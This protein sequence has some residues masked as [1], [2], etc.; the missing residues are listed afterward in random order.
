MI[1]A[2][3]FFTGMCLTAVFGLIVPSSV[4]AQVTTDVPGIVTEV[5]N[6]YVGKS[7]PEA[8]GQQTWQ[9]VMN[10]ADSGDDEAGDM[11]LDDDIV[12]LTDSLL[13]QLDLDA[14]D[15]LL[16]EN[17]DTK[18]ILFSDIVK[19]LLNS[20]TEISKSEI[21]RKVIAMFFSEVAEYRVLM[22]RL[23]VLTIAFAFFNSFISTS[24]DRSI[25]KMGFF[26]YF[27]VLMALLT[28]SYLLIS[29]LFEDVMGR[30]S[31]MM[32]AL[33]PAFAMTLFF[34]SAQT[35]AAVFYQI[36]VAVIWLVER[37]L[38]GIVAPLVHIYTVLQILNCFT[39]EKM[40]SRL[41]S[42]L[43]RLILWTL[44]ALLAGV[45]GINVIESMIAPSLD[46]LKKLSVTKAMGMIPGLGNVTEAVS[47]LF[48]GSALVIKNGVGAAAMIALLSVVLMP[49]LKMLVFLL[50]YKAAGAMVQPF[51]GS[52]V[53][54]CIDSIGE[55]TAL[56]VRTLLVG[57]L[58][59]LITIALVITAVR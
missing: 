45:T 41:T 37:L 3:K 13:E 32:E 9:T 7:D 20:E 17:E 33:I 15:D 26:M 23:M 30:V 54:G 36:A 47:N 5:R 35:T 57:T 31:E 39:G 8:D 44:R 55:S 14:V 40:I 4:N 48:L 38:I 34:S 59:F 50:V 46:N 56:L 58:L 43:R 11:A 10:T 49:V 19:E 2:G 12:D 22:I 1:W 6:T 53:S 28:E 52:Q 25:S 18:G 42:L 16:S 21:G 27:L 51:A 24:P 29:D